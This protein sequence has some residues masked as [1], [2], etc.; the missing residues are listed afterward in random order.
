MEEVA[1]AQGE[2]DAAQR[3]AAALA[4]E[5]EGERSERAMALEEVGGDFGFVVV[6]L[7]LFC[8]AE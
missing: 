2:R 3:R 4:A 5:V 6:L 7:M 1:L 8:G